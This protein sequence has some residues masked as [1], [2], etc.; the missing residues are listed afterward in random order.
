[1]AVTKKNKPLMPYTVFV[2]DVP[3]DNRYRL[4][5]HLLDHNDSEEIWGRV[6]EA[7]MDIVQAEW[8]REDILIEYMLEGD[9]EPL[10]MSHLGFDALVNKTTDNT[11][12]LRRLDLTPNHIMVIAVDN[13]DGCF[14][15]HFKQAGNR[16]T[17]TSSPVGDISDCMDEM[18]E[19]MAEYVK[20]PVV[21]KLVNES[22][23]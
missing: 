13:Q 8:P 16:W 19:T 3:N 1:M 10:D 6:T 17:A 7:L 15:H 22:P 23:F 20:E 4:S 5:I 2:V 11:T 18:V 12:I 14:T 9:H 21:Y